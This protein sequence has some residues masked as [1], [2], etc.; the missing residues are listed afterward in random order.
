MSRKGAIS[1]AE[2][3]FDDGSFFSLLSQ[4]VAINTGSRADDRKPGMLEFLE[5]EMIPSL[6]TIDFKCRVVE[7]PEEPCAPFLIAHRIEDETFPCILIYGH[8]DTVPGMDDKWK[9]G[10]S[11]FKLTKDGDLWYG[12]GAAD[13][14]GQHAINIAALECVIKEKKKLG[15]NVKVLIE[16]GEEAGSPGLHAICEREKKA[17]KADVLI[18]SD[19]PRIDPD[20]PTIFGGSRAVYN[21]DLSINLREGGHHSGNWGGLLANPGIILSETRKI[22]AG[23]AKPGQIP[24]LWDGGAARR[25]VDVLERDLRSE[26]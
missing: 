23:E 5:Q 20:T 7:N 26:L 25:I 19:G 17:L 3:F 14:K 24:E 8:G 1:R 11:P 13:N 21:F 4:R 6:E 10:L 22:L 16:M 9:K 18:A 2:L 12:R 15:F